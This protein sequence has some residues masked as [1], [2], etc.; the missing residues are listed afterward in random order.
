VKPLELL[1]RRFPERWG[2]H[3]TIH[4]DDIRRNF[5]L[6]PGEGLLCSAF[7]YKTA[8]QA[9]ADTELLA[10]EQYLAYLAAEVPDF[11]S[12]DHAEW[13]SVVVQRVTAAAAARSSAASSSSG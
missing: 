6:N 11:T 12:V 9:A 2:A 13:R 5:A 1:W 4:L 3:N 8:A 10:C 7:H